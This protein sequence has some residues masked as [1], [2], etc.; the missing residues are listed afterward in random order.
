MQ[1]RASSTKKKDATAQENFSFT[2][3]LSSS[4]LSVDFLLFLVKTLR[5]CC[6]AG[7]FGDIRQL[8]YGLRN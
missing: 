1:A 2:S 7:E 3:S 6:T 8:F 5:V 4:A